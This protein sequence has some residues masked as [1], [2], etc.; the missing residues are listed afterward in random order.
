MLA[1][2]PLAS[3]ENFPAGQS[4]HSV[5]PLKVVNFASSHVSHLAAP[6]T[7]H[8]NFPASHATVRVVWKG[9]KKEN[10]RNLKNK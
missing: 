10:E 6:Y 1:E 4:S 7:N 5:E 8:P 2:V 9:K 3:S